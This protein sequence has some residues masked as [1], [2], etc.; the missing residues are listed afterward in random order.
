MERTDLFQLL[1]D[2]HIRE[3]LRKL[4]LPS[5]IPLFVY[6]FMFS[7]PTSKRNKF[8]FMNNI[9]L[10]RYGINTVIRRFRLRH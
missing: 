1:V 2:L 7:F 8:V 10:L 5:S 9:A 4:Y 6:V 3:R